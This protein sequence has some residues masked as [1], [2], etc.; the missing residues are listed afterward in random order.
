LDRLGEVLPPEK[1]AQIKASAVQTTDNGAS[2]TDIR[3][4][5]A[6]G[7]SIEGLV[8]QAVAKHIAENKLY[9]TM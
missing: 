1:V 7:E 3:R 4:R 6:A 5:I 9:R 2:A 8:S